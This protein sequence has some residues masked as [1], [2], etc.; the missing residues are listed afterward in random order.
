MVTDYHKASLAE[1]QS[2]AR[3]KLREP[4]V[5]CPHCEAKTTVDDLL[6]HVA[7]RCEG[8]KPPHPLSRWVALQEALALGVP[9]GTLH[10][11]CQQGRVRVDTSQE[12]LR[13]CKRDLVLQ[14][15]VRRRPRAEGHDEAD[16]GPQLDLCFA[17]GDDDG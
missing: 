10:R 6:Q 5:T 2:I 9:R 8:H 4:A 7:D 13:F 11:W 15:A 3:G 14:L 1:K 17:E 12:F 16:A